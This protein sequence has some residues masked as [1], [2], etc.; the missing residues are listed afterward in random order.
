[1][2]PFS[3]WPIILGLYW[4]EANASGAVA[5][6]VAGV[7]CFFALSILKP[8]MGGIHAIV[9]TSIVAFAAFVIGAKCG[10]PASEE[11]IRLFW[12]EGNGT[13]STHE[14]LGEGRTLLREGGRAPMLPPSLPSLPFQKTCP[15]IESPLRVF[16]SGTPLT[17]S[18]I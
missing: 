16:P 10:R 11:V 15:Y 5:S 6:I 9:P 13:S 8:G 12:G 2:R 7:A 17:G 18:E 3:F 4:K 14:T 1:M